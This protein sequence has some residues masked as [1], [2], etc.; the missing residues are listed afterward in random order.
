MSVAG[1]KAP[2]NKIHEFWRTPKYAKKYFC[3]SFLSLSKPLKK[4]NKRYRLKVN[5]SAQCNG[6]VDAPF[7]SYTSIF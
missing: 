1:R 4:E 6:N 3:L 5:I 7:F 2:R